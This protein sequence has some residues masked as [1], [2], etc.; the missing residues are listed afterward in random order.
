M[1]GMGR[2]LILKR[3]S[4][5]DTATSAPAPSLPAPPG[6]ATCRACVGRTLELPQNA[7]ALLCTD[8]QVA[9]GLSLQQSATSLAVSFLHCHVAQYLPEFAA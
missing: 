2:A 9:L 1:D 5:A 8:E 3:T 6:P 4:R 7:A